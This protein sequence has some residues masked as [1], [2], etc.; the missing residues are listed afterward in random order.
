M[1]K[2]EQECILVAETPELVALVSRIWIKKFSDPNVVDLKDRKSVLFQSR[3]NFRSEPS[4]PILK[5]P[6]NHMDQYC[7]KSERKKKNLLYE[8]GA[9]PLLCEHCHI[10][11]HERC[12]LI[13]DLDFQIACVACPGC[14]DS[15]PSRSRPRPE[16]QGK[17]FS[18][19]PM[20][21]F[22]REVLQ[23]FCHPFL[24]VLVVFLVVVLF[25]V[26]GRTIDVILMFWMAW[27]LVLRVHWLIEGSSLTAA[28]MT[29]TRRAREL[30]GTWCLS[31]AIG[32]R[33][34]DPS[35]Q[36]LLSFPG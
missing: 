9:Q 7:V 25:W 16:L 31:V 15:P 14:I 35:N 26:I 19:H 1:W 8:R 24:F 34:R 32:L 3:N 17:D 18:K 36:L 20:S 11:S 12:E 33:R 6:G 5:L 27:S 30:P 23:T 29:R 22:L 2:G 10:Y 13:L 4:C 28:S 21:R